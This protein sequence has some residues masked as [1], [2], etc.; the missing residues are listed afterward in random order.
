MFSHWTEAFPYR[1]ATASSVA[2]VLLKMIIP[3]WGTSLKLHSDQGSHLPGQALRQIC[4][5]WPVLQ[6]FHCTHHPRSSG[7]VKHT[8]S[9]IKTQLAK[10]VKP[11][12]IP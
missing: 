6:H 11:L 9:I 7:L 3:T 2:K 8:N 4:A 5:V 1:Q 10:F 12:Q